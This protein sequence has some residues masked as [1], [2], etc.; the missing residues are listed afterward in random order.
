MSVGSLHT[1][2]RSCFDQLQQ[3]CSATCVEKSPA[4]CCS[5]TC[6]LWL[7]KQLCNC[8]QLCSSH[9]L[10]QQC[11]SATCAEKSP[12]SYCS[13]TCGFWLCKQLCSCIQ[14]CSSCAML[15]Q[16]CSATCA[17]KS[18]A[19]SAVTPVGSG[20]ASSSAIAFSFAVVVPCCSSAACQPVLRRVL[21][22]LQSHLWVLALQ[23]ALQLHSAL[24]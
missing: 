12:A 13:H 7:C 14:L 3:C 20:F 6:G 11:C 24:Q 8:I 17:D 15:Q 5:H 22:V 23:A 1:C 16:C 4:S 2:M 18:P 9:A 10:L 19:S 21:L